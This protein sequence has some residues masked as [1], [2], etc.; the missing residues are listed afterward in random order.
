MTFP[1]LSRR[2]TI[3][4][5]GDSR[6]DSMRDR[7]V[8]YV[9]SNKGKVGKFRNRF[10][11]SSNDTKVCCLNGTSVNHQSTRGEKSKRETPSIFSFI[12]FWGMRVLLKNLDGNVCPI[13]IE[14]T[15]NFVSLTAKIQK[16]TGIDPS[17]QKMLYY[18][19]QLW[20]YP[21]RTVL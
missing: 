2:Q 9:S 11:S 7:R 17:R 6:R 19:I 16:K 1:R 5:D 3:G 12:I 21:T 8:S 10:L 14:P 20:S 18:G 4:H 15:D 13:D